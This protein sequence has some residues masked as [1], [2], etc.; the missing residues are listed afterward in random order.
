MEVQR[1]KSLTLLNS[2]GSNEFSKYEWYRQD[3]FHEEA[4]VEIDDN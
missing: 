4:T 1:V 2:I 3:E